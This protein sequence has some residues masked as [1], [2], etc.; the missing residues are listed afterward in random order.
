M[1]NLN[2]ECIL[3][4]SLNARLL[5]VISRNLIKNMI[6]DSYNIFTAFGKRPEHIRFVSEKRKLIIM[7]SLPIPLPTQYL[8]NAFQFSKWFHIHYLIW[9]SMCCSRK[10]IRLESGNLNCSL[11]SSTQCQWPWVRYL[12]CLGSRVLIC[13]MPVWE[14]IISK[15]L[16][17]LKLCNFMI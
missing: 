16:S 14:Q 5:E 13:N 9:E 15:V 12:I 1:L 3:V 11:G 6:C 4:W 8:H 7:L 2:E 17:I 10:K